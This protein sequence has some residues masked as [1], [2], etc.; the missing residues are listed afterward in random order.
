MHA[1]RL[2]AE[3][4][5]RL[6]LQHLRQPEHAPQVAARRAHHERREGDGL[7]LLHLREITAVLLEQIDQPERRGIMILAHLLGGSG[8]HLTCEDRPRRPHRPKPGQAAHRLRLALLHHR[9]A[10]RPAQHG[11]VGDQF[12]DQA[13]AFGD[14]RPDHRP[15]QHDLHARHGAGLPDCARRAVEAGKETEL[16]LRKA[17]PGRTVPRRDA[18]MTGEHQFEPA[19]DAHAVD[20]GD[21]RHGQLL[22]RIQQLVDRPDALDDF[23]LGVERV[24]LADVG[25]DDE[26]RLV[27]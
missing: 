17:H 10:R 22:Q 11:R 2:E 5:R 6:R 7:L 1:A 13:H 19:A 9:L 26:T 8:P 12:V 16:D 21:D 20:R 4:L 14:R 25:P 3:V 23:S 15:R 27:A 24:E 18:V